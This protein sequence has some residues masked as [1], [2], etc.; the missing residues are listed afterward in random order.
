MN[1]EKW[2]FLKVYRFKTGLLLLQI[3]TILLCSNIYSSFKIDFFFFSVGL[4]PDASRLGS[5]NKLKSLKLS[6]F[7]NQNKSHQ[8]T[9]RSHQK[10]GN[11]WMSIERK[12]IYTVR[13]INE[14]NVYCFSLRWSINSWKVIKVIYKLSGLW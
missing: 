10:F 5:K 8:I 12:S 11:R 4:Q 7:L 14:C 2:F 6:F 1:L 13:V 3:S 9:D